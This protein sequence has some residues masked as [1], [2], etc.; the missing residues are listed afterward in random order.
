MRL[1]DVVS[2]FRTPVKS[3][4]YIYIFNQGLKSQDIYEGGPAARVIFDQQTTQLW[5]YQFVC[6]HDQVCASK[7]TRIVRDNHL[8][9]QRTRL[10]G[11]RFKGGEECSHQSYDI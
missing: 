6:L 4:K 8:K 3:C 9:D 7:E 2:S 10:E 1:N 5:T 11:L